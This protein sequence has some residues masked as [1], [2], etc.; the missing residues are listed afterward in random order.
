MQQVTRPHDYVPRHGGR[1]SS[2]WRRRLVAV[3]G[4]VAAAVAV[5][6]VE[7]PGEDADLGV[8][9]VAAGSSQLSEQV[10]A[11]GR[12]GPL[13]PVAEDLVAFPAAESPPVAVA[14][15][16]GL[17]SLPPPT[18]VAP[19]EVWVLPSD[20]EVTSDFGPR[21]GRQHS[22]M[23]LAAG[24]GAPVYAASAGTVVDAGWAGGYGRRV[25]LEHEWGVVTTYGHASELLVEVGDVVGAGDVIALEG[26]TGRSTGPHVHL[27]VRLGGV[28][29]P[30][31][32][33]RPFLEA[34]GVEVPP[35]G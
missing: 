2:R 33:P 35:A 18:L 24:Y 9:V 12:G 14:P 15:V 34:R 5:G 8:D 10:W 1:P 11:P 16:V 31:V 29:G 21:W 7:L 13:E 20:G 27:A 19:E 23:D 4:L 32:D 22:G 6:V 25:Q 26:S 3:L 30:K 28:D 17:P